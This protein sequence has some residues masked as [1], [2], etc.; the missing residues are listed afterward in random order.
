MVKLWKIAVALAGG[1]E[2]SDNLFVLPSFC[3]QHVIANV[4]LHVGRA[5]DVQRP[6]F[7]I[8]K[9]FTLSSYALAF[10]DAIWRWLWLRLK[11]IKVVV[12][13]VQYV[14]SNEIEKRC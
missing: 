2:G 6:S 11:V 14:S 3:L 4:K 7:C 8:A 13:N 5:L 1:T 10:D 12:R 9:Q